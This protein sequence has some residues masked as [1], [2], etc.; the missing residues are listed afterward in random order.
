LKAVVYYLVQVPNKEFGKRLWTSV[1]SLNWVVI[2]FKDWEKS[3]GS[4]VYWAKLHKPDGRLCN[5]A[6][7]WVKSNILF[8]WLLTNSNVWLLRTV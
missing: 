1:N 7:V 2:V 5:M 3:W 6:C 8:N 4:L